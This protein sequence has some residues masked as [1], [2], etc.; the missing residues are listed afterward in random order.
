VSVNES[1]NVSVTDSYTTGVNVMGISRAALAAAL[2]FATG[3]RLSA[4]E[5]VDQAT[6]YCG[7]ST[8]TPM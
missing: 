7:R 4:Q 5:S 1:E 3:L 2:L 8:I 6:R